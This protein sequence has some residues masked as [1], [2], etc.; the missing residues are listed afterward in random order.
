MSAA[1]PSQGAN[2]PPL[3]AAQRRLSLIGRITMIATVTV[4]LVC[5]LALA[6]DPRYAGALAGCSRHGRKRG[7]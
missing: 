1:G 3:G 6:V 2:T 5:R 4:G 7:P